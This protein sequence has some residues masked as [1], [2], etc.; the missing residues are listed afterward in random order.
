MI[1]WSCPISVEHHALDALHAALENGPSTVD[2][3]A[4]AAGVSKRYMDKLLTANREHGYV[5]KGHDGRW[6]NNYAAIE[7]G[8]RPR[9]KYCRRTV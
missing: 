3:L 1:D 4:T 7:D 9:K 8:F 2:E 5:R 6:K